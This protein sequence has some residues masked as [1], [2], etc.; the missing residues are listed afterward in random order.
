MSSAIL[1]PDMGQEVEV[2]F[3]EGSAR[4]DTRRRIES[5]P[6]AQCN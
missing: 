1:A 5:W 6:I 2:L 3:A 4:M